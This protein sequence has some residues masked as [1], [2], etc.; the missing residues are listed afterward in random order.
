MLAAP[1]LPVAPPPSQP[2]VAETLTAAPE[3]AEPMPALPLPP[4]P[5]DP[6]APPDLPLAPI[7]FS[8]PPSVSSSA[9]TLPFAPQVTAATTS[10]GSADE[11]G[12]A[13]IS[14]MITDDEWA[15]ALARREPAFPETP[16]PPPGQESEASTELDNEPAAPRRLATVRRPWVTRFAIAAAII[17][18]IALAVALVLPT[19]IR[20]VFPGRL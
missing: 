18:V 4:P 11:V 2:T 16:E 15:A 7:P 3:V 1:V 19:I 8:G 17:V 14:G 20:L 9:Q 13:P 12:A 5:A 10:W 6:S